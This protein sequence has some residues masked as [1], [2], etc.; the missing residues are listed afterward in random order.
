MSTVYDDVACITC[1]A[2]PFDGQGRQPFRDD[3]C[4]QCQLKDNPEAFAC[5]ECGNLETAAGWMP[6]VGAKLLA[7]KLCHSCD[8]WA[9]RVDK[10][11]GSTSHPVVNGR[12]Y[13]Y[14]P[15]QPM[16]G[17]DKS[18]LG[19][20]GREFVIAWADGRKVT[21]N[22]LWCGGDVP[23]HFRD[24]LPDTATFEAVR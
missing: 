20:G 8:L 5:V 14:D 9:G 7:S 2:G 1:G 18:F 22:N 17:G 24:R 10:I 21:T 16:R 4:K 13:S 23:D 11:A 12:C 6:G 19:H 15:K 3:V